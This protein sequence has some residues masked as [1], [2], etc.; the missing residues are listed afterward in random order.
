MVIGIRK[1]VSSTNRTEIPST[2]S[3][4]FRP[5]IHVASSTNCMPVL[6]GSKSFSRIKDTN[7]VAVVA[8]SAS[9]LALRC[10]A[11]SLPRRNS[12]STTA[13]TAGRK[14]MRERRL[15]MDQ[16]P[17]ESVIQVSKA[18]IPSTMAKA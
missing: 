4:Y 12:A 2:P 8:I 11:A 1:V 18:A 9:H 6:A 3:L 14:V 13:A 16:C 15:F 10:A 5:A 17:T 7:N